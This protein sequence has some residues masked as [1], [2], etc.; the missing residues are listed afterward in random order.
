MGNQ[1]TKLVQALINRLV[2]LKVLLQRQQAHQ[3]RQHI[4]NRHALRMGHNHA[5]HTTRRVI[6]DTRM[7]DGQHRLELGQNIRIARQVRA[8]VGRVVHQ[9]AG[10]IRRIALG[11]GIRVRQTLEQQ[12]QNSG[13]E[14]CHRS[15]HVLCALRN[16]AHGR[17]P[18]E[19]L[20]RRSKLH[21]GLLED[22]PQLAKGGAHGECQRDDDVEGRV[23]DNP[24][25]F[26]GTLDFLL[27]LVAEVLLRGVRACDEGREHGD[28]LLDEF[29]LSEDARASGLEDG[30][31]VAVDLGDDVAGEG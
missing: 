2:L 22:L 23:D 4:A 7:V 20:L 5:A 24:V 25:V 17:R 21:D 9:L 8:G 31:D 18:L 28:S 30:G 26:R 15:T 11:L 10:G 14:G 19:V 27:V 12:L 3:H 16:H 29:G 13:R 6:L 1:L